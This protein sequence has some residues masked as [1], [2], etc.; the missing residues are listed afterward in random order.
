MILSTGSCAMP[1]QGCGSC[2]P[3]RTRSLVKSSRAWS[4]RRF[5]KP[6]AMRSEQVPPPC[7]PAKGVHSGIFTSNRASTRLSTGRAL[8]WASEHADR[9]PEELF[10]MFTFLSRDGR[11]L[12]IR[13]LGRGD[14]EA[15]STWK[16]DPV[17]T[18]SLSEELDVN[19]LSPR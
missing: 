5:V 6:L 4:P 2:L 10:K 19:L 12:C 14:G 15:S 1:C 13:C 9:T 7:R 17:G 11:L 8:S 16:S 3:G 18:L